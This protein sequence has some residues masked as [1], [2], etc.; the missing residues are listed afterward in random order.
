[1]ETLEQI[2]CKVEELL[3]DGKLKL[4]KP[5]E[6]QNRKAEMATKHLKSEYH[7]QIREFQTRCWQAEQLGLT[8][9]S[10]LE[11]GE[12]LMGKKYR[13]VTTWWGWDGRVGHWNS[14]DPKEHVFEYFYRKD[15]YSGLNW[16]QEPLMIKRLFGPTLYLGRMPN[17]HDEVPYPALL[18][19]EQFKELKLFNC[20]SIVGPKEAFRK[21]SKPVPEPID[22]VLLGCI[23]NL[24]YKPNG[25]DDPNYVAYYPLAKW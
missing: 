5:L 22:P 24:E 15:S 17:L 3:A 12:L 8:R 23:Y 11:V 19:V 21:L 13:K 16:G 10:L 1:M 2:S 14:N 7:D 18:K 4:P 9:M 25:L 6:D 20:F